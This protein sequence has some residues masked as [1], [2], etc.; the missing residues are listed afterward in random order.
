MTHTCTCT[1]TSRH[2]PRHA[3]PSIPA[4]LPP[5]PGP[6]CL[7][8]LSSQNVVQASPQAASD[9]LSPHHQPP[10]ARAEWIHLHRQCPQG[11]V[12]ITTDR[13]H[14]GKKLEVSPSIANPRLWSRASWG[15]RVM[16]DNL[17]FQGKHSNYR[18]LLGHRNH[19]LK[20][21]FRVS[22]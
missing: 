16:P 17:K 4:D 6:P 9:G 7:L 21:E 19:Y 14:H 11:H 10:Q 2:L 3:V 22:S 5:S 20:G 18:H 15:T 13:L 8:A 1:C 12:F